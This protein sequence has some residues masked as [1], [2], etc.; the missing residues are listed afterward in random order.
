[1]TH[2][3]IFGAAQQPAY[4][5]RD[6]TRVP[7]F[8]DDKPLIVFDGVCIFCSGF[9]KF[10][11]RHDR[12]NRLNL[13]TAQS[14]LGHALYIHYGL[15][16]ENYETNIVIRDGRAHFK[17]DAFFEVMKIL[18][19]GWPLLAFLQIFPRRPRNWLYDRIASNR[20][21]LFGKADS[22]IL[23]PPEHKAKILDYL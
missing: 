15:D 2:I 21:K 16:P 6:D 22:C 1:M 10:I 4:S 5:Y 8:P 9:A 23:L 13:C 12:K 19:S 14:K 18:G 20:Y 7:T 17:S 3:D 11:L